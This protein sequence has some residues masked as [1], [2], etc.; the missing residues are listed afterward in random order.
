M[1]VLYVKM[2]CEVEWI[3]LKKPAFQ[4]VV[5]VVNAANIGRLL[6]LTRPLSESLF[7]YNER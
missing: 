2:D 7:S 3:T 4:N 5:I 1:S 6:Y